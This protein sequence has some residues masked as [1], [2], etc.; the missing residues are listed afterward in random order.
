[1]SQDMPQQLQLKTASIVAIGVFDVRFFTPTALLKTDILTLPEATAAEGMTII[2]GRVANF[3]SGPLKVAAEQNRIHIERT[4]PPYIKVADILSK[5]LRDNPGGPSKIAAL[6]VNT[7]SYWTVDSF[8]ARDRLGRQ[9]A[10]LG[11]WGRWSEALKAADQFGPRDVRHPGVSVITMRLPIREDRS[12]GWIDVRVSPSPRDI[13][14]PELIIAT[15]DHYAL[16]DNDDGADPLALL[17]IAET[18]FDACMKRA[19]DIVE[20]V[21]EQAK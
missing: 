3:E 8:E 10:P 5:A 21:L 6:G 2:P 11:A 12:A 16:P 18:R 14:V 17:A 7:M 13:T 15:N 20:S 1:M 9:I 19:D 4:A